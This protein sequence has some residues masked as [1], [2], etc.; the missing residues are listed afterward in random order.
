[1]LTHRESLKKYNILH[2]HAKSMR[3][4]KQNKLTRLSA[5]N[6]EIHDYG[7]PRIA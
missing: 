7:Q 2:H 1:M 3:T 5:K 6:P 4:N